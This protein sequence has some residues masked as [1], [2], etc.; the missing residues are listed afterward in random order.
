VLTV[1]G[2]YQQAKIAYLQSLGQRL[3][4]TVALFV[5]LG[6]GWTKSAINAADSLENKTPLDTQ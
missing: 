3:Q 6:G 2:Q 4:D 1:I 5:A